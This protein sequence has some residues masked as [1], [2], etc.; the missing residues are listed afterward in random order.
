MFEFRHLSNPFTQLC[1]Y[2]GEWSYNRHGLM[3][4]AGHM[5][6]TIYVGG[7]SKGKDDKDKQQ[8]DKAKRA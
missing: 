4:G 5:S 8:K 1:V 6:I 3:R 2:M 7:G